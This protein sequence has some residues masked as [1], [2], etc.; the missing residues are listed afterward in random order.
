[1]LNLKKNLSRGCVIPTY[2]FRC[3]KC[4]KEYEVLTKYDKT[5]KY[6]KIKCPEC[7]SKSKEQLICGGNFSFSNPVG[8][9][10]WNSE[11]SGHDY[12]FKH[13]AP[14]VRKQ[15][16]DAEKASHMG[17]N[18]YNDIDDISSGNYFGEVK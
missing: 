14:D 17:T 4:G 9:D 12:R 5:G 13:K 6:P 1:M 16:E 8:T 15:R 11:S 10:R 3:K 7:S 2:E 18:P